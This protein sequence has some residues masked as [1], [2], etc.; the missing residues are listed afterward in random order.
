MKINS[1]INE[2]L[3]NKDKVNKYNLSLLINAERKYKDKYIQKVMLK[4]K[5]NILSERKISMQKQKNLSQKYLKNNYMTKNNNNS[6]KKYQSISNF[7][8]IKNL[9]KLN[10]PLGPYSNIL[11]GTGGFCRR[12]TK[13]NINYSQIYPDYSKIIIPPK[14]NQNNIIEKNKKISKLTK[15][16]P[17]NNQY[18]QINNYLEKNRN[19]Y[20]T[21]YLNYINK[22]S[23]KSNI[24]FKI[25]INEVN[26]NIRYFKINKSINCDNYN[27]SLKEKDNL[28]KDK[29]NKNNKKRRTNSFIEENNKICENGHFSFEKISKNNN[30]S[31]EIKNKL[32]LIKQ[33]NEQFSMNNFKKKVFNKLY[34]IDNIFLNYSP[35]LKNLK[36]NDNNTKSYLTNCDVCSK[37]AEYSIIKSLLS[38]NDNKEDNI[39]KNFI[40]NINQISNISPRIKLIQKD[41]SNCET[42]NNKNTENKIEINGNKA[43]LK[44]ENEKMKKSKELNEDNNIDKNEYKINN[45]SIKKE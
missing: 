15:N 21:N 5:V 28:C 30:N 19:K 32:I 8:K 38:K 36:N 12:I 25:N 45:D 13:K 24:S 37:Q 31:N 22:R 35:S 11:N 1:S 20:K 10:R 41:N 16:K 18:I 44:N 42:K 27:S 4:K 43:I 2:I 34:P 14:N 23:N 39:N 33:V 17:Y 3:R 6:L 26:K 7:S 9:N 29:F 40:I